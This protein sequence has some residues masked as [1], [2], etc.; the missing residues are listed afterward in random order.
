LIGNSLGKLGEDIA[1]K[2]LQNKGFSIIE[3]NYWK[4]YGEI[5]IVAKKGS[6]LH[7]VEVKAIK[8]SSHHENYNAGE[9]VHA[10]K[11]RK[12]SRVIQ[13]Y[14]MKKQN[15]EADWQFD[16]CIVKIDTIQKKA[17]VKYLANEILPE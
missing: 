8:F 9:N 17:K 11:L 3:R 1:A 16:V 10:L 13:S 4:P 12:L 14:L 5:D 15:R 2:Y 7:F 6:K